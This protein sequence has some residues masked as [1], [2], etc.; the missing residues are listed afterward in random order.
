[1]G[2]ESEGHLH[3]RFTARGVVRGAQKRLVPRVGPLPRT[4]FC[5]WA[6]LMDLTASASRHCSAI[7]RHSSGHIA[8]TLSF[9]AISTEDSTPQLPP[10]GPLSPLRSRTLRLSL[11]KRC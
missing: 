3:L 6:A 10:D 9:P 1:M 2:F 4:V 7:V 8:R 11:M 5:H